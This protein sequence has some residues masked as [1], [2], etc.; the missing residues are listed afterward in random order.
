M[1]PSCL[2][3]YGSGNILR[4]EYASSDTRSQARQV[5]ANLKYAE[6]VDRNPQLFEQQKHR[7]VGSSGYTSTN[8]LCNE[9]VIIR[10]I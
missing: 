10:I 5:C 8:N 9:E 2:R 3:A 4:R 7:R 6:T 1:E